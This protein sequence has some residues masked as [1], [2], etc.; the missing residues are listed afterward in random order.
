MS[1][2]GIILARQTDGARGPVARRLVLPAAMPTPVSQIKL[3]QVVLRAPIRPRLVLGSGAAT[4]IAAADIPLD[5]YNTK[6]TGETAP[7]SG[8]GLVGA[9][10]P[11]DP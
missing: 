1:H 10:S 3:R 9:L 2:A 7:A 6:G 8:A 5:C 4:R 11:H